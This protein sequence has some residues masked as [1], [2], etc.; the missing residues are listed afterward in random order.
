MWHELESAVCVPNAEAEGPVHERGPGSSPKAPPPTVLTILPVTGDDVVLTQQA[1][2]RRQLFQ[3]ELAV[4]VGQKHVVHR[5]PIEPRPDRCAVPSVASVLHHAELGSLVLQ[6]MQHQG[7]VIRASI[8]HDDDF[9]VGGVLP[10]DFGR[11]RDHPRNVAF[12]VE[13]RDHHRETH[14]PEP[15]S[16]TSR[17]QSRT[18]RRATASSRARSGETLAMQKQRGYVRH[19]IGKT[20]V[21]TELE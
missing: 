9:E 19:S 10:T 7:G 3:I 20:W 11:L 2:R 13:T 5:R 16:G 18:C 14:R 21:L 1:H 4:A 17:L 8:V 6:R 15:N 12:L